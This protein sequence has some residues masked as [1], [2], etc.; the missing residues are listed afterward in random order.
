MREICSASAQEAREQEEAGSGED[1]GPGFLTG[2]QIIK[3]R[4][5][6]DYGRQMYMLRRDHSRGASGMPQLRAGIY[7]CKNRQERGQ[8]QKARETHLG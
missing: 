7:S 8:T 5:E 2:K 1:P 6:K 4:R 3:T